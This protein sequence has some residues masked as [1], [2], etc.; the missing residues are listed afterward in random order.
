MQWWVE[1]IN[2]W[3]TPAG[4]PLF[5]DNSL[6]GVLVSAERTVGLTGTVPLES[7]RAVSVVLALAACGWAVRRFTRREIA[8]R[9]GGR[10]PRRDPR[11]LIAHAADVLAFGLI[12][13][14]MVWEHHYVL[15]L[16]AVL[17][18]AVT[19]PPSAYMRIAAG[20]ALMLMVP[21]FDI[22]WIS[23]HRLVGLL[24]VLSAESALRPAKLPTEARA[25]IP[26]AANIARNG[27]S[28]RP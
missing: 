20:A 10:D 5:R 11:A 23:D 17:V 28:G 27:R 7:A 26:A 9:A 3:R 8:A 2:R 15:A 6:L 19:A 4:T 18:A 14:P 1:F 13:S 12:M 16:P 25:T 21:L 22:M 24:L